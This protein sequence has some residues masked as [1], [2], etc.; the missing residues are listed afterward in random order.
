[1]DPNS[2]ELGENDNAIIYKVP[3]DKNWFKRE[4]KKIVQERNVFFM[5]DFPF[6]FVHIPC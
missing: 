3:A 4:E 5:S 6:F 2:L 1:M